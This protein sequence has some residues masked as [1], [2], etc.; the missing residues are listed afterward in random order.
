MKIE[1]NKAEA[2]E[3]L[4]KHLQAMFPSMDV[5]LENSYGGDF[6]YTVESSTI[7]VSDKSKE[8]NV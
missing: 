7:I 5:K 4:R 8:E 3:L 1:I 2:E 6:K